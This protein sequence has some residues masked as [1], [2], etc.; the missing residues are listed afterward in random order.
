MTAPWYPV[1]KDVREHGQVP[2]LF[3]RLI[4]IGKPEQVEVGVRGHHVFCL[5]ANPAAH[6]DV[7]ERGSGPIRVD[8]EADPSL[9]FLAVAAP[10]T[11]DVE[12]H[13]A[14]V[15]DLDELDVAT[16]PDHLT[17]DLMAEDQ[18]LGGSGAAANHVLIAAADVSGNNLQDDA[19]LTLAADIGGVD[20][21]AVPRLELRELD[22]AYLDACPVRQYV[23]ARFA[24]IVVVGLSVK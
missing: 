16:D 3:H 24:L 10:A 1:G 19:V 23:T 18:P 13:R 2:D 9:A 6:I 11:R 5:T 22:V 7:P 15:A 4:P 17:G 21:G 8:V 14:Q 20:A 12:R